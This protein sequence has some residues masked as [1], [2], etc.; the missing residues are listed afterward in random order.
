L[1]MCNGRWVEV[2][3]MEGNARSTI[4]K[5]LMIEHR[6]YTSRLSYGQTS[7]KIPICCSMR[8]WLLEDVQSIRMFTVG[9]N[10]GRVMVSL[11]VVCLVGSMG[12]GVRGVEG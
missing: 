10:K 2:S 7:G 11:W 6:V 9:E 5:F 3:N 4:P 8:C 1:D 12:D